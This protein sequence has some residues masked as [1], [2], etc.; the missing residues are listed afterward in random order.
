MNRSSLLWQELGSAFPWEAGGWSWRL[1]SQLTITLED[2]E[3]PQ[4]AAEIVFAEG[5]DEDESGGSGPLQG[6]AL[7]RQP[8]STGPTSPTTYTPV[9]CVGMGE[10][11]WFGLFARER[12]KEQFLKNI[13]IL[14]SNIWIIE[15]YIF[16]KDLISPYGTC[17]PTPKF[18]LLPL[19]CLHSLGGDKGKEIYYHIKSF[20]FCFKDIIF[21]FDERTRLEEWKDAGQ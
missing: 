14:N 19:D 16:N 7:G 15:S 20:C 17:H 1:F 12:K 11:K 21:H 13:N 4:V 9:R 3:P 10:N 18:H 6:A 8:A 2:V 5:A